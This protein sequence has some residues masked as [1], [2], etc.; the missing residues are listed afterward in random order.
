[1]GQNGGHKEC[2]RP[3]AESLKSMAPL[4]K[5]KHQE[6]KVSTGGSGSRQ[7]TP[8]SGDVRRGGKWGRCLHRACETAQSTTE[9]CRARRASRE[10]NENVGRR[11]TPG[12]QRN[13]GSLRQTEKEARTAEGWSRERP[14]SQ[15]PVKHAGRGERRQGH[16]QMTTAGRGKH[17]IWHRRD[18]RDMLPNQRASGREHGGLKL[19][20]DKTA[21]RVDRRGPRG[22]S[23]MNKR[24]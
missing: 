8:D 11:R 15:R 7:T 23:L 10:Q 19:H 2:T 21:L 1:M 14:G 12:G 4:N 5:E 17:D 18:L 6:N 20:R 16:R 24:W 9:C 3:G 13:Q 22:S